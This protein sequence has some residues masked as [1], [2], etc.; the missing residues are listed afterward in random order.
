LWSDMIPC[1]GVRGRDMGRDD[2][3]SVYGRLVGY[4]DTFSPAGMAKHPVRLST[5]ALQKERSISHQKHHVRIA[6]HTCTGAK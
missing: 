5:P 2:L 4:K 3:V 1:G 6:G